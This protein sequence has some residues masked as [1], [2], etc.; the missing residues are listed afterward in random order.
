MPARKTKKIPSKVQ[1]VEAV[2]DDRVFQGYAEYYDDTGLLALDGF[3]YFVIHPDKERAN[4]RR[5]SAVTKIVP[6]KIIVI[7]EEVE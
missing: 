3:G 5:R 6:V 4:I 2:L 1:E 7:E